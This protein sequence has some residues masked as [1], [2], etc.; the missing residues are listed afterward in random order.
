[1]NA[2][3]RIMVLADVTRNCLRLSFA[4][5]VGKSELESYD[6]DVDQALKSLQ[7]GFS[8]VTD[9]SDL[10]EMSL[11][12][13]AAIDRTMEKMKEAGVSLDCQ[14]IECAVFFDMNLI[15]IPHLGDFHDRLFNL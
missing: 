11:G 3:G 5:V 15:I 7:R 4:G 10:E 13:V 8:L 2:S 1:M 12:S 9:L 14:F 6:A